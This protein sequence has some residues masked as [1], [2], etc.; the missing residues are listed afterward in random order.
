MIQVFPCRFYEYNYYFL[1]LIHSLLIM[2]IFVADVFMDEIKTHIIISFIL[3]MKLSFIVF[4]WYFF[5]FSSSYFVSFF[6]HK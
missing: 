1:F 2:I 4:F 5:L 6:M 3:I